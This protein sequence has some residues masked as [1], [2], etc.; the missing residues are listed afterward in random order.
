M[1]L[2]ESLSDGKLNW[3]IIDFDLNRLI[4]ANKYEGARLGGGFR[5]SNKLL[6]WVSVGAYGGYGLKDKTEKYGGDINFTINRRNDVGLKFSYQKDI[7]EPG[8]V[9]F[10]DYKISMFSTAGN[11][12]LFNLD[13]MNNSEKAE[14][15]FQF[16]TAKYL[17]VYTFINQESVT[18]TND[19]FYKYRDQNDV[20][21]SAQKYTFNEVGA[22][23]RYAFKEKVIKS[24][25][26][27][28]SVRSKFPILFAKVEH[29]LKDFDGEFEYT[30]L[31]FRAEKR[32]FIKNLGHP[33]FYIETGIINGKVP[34]HKLNS[35]LGTMN[36]NNSIKS[37]RVSTDNAFETM[38]PYEFFSSEYVHFHFRHSFGS[39]LFKYKKFEP[40]FVLT[41]SVGFGA[42]SYAG[43]HAGVAFK[44]MEKGYYESGL[45]INDIVRWYYISLGAGAFYRY[46]PYR[47]SKSSDNLAVKLSLGFV[48]PKKLKFDKRRN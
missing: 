35:A 9:D 27:K 22:E 24:G 44:T 37:I 3:G 6:K 30:R 13:R 7:A 23:F 2:F 48:I 1:A 14:A 31:T 17:K 38:L 34:Q 42:L 36:L 26:K 8:V 43:T 41:S 45:V 10:S 5:T 18:V 25:D 4:G 47:F 32:F 20:L 46:G 40:E 19:Y 39:L 21:V 16:R 29:G 33:K 28:Y 12:R 11:R 15:R